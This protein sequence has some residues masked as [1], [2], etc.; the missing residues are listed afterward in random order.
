ME[1]SNEKIYETMPEC[2]GEF[3]PTLDLSLETFNPENDSVVAAHGIQENIYYEWVD[4][5]DEVIHAL[6]GCTDIPVVLQVSYY[7]DCILFKNKL[8][9]STIVQGMAANLSCQ[10]NDACVNNL[11]QLITSGKSSPIEDVDN[12]I[13]L[14]EA[15]AEQWGFR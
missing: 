5:I 6:N 11:S 3:Y 2:F 8:I 13:N 12:N 4:R 10:D 7:G 9:H 15:T 14:A 1:I